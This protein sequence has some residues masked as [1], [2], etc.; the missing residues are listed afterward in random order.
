MPPEETLVGPPREGESWGLAEGDQ[1]VPG[2]LALGPVGGGHDFEVL[3]GWDDHRHSL[4]VVK[5][6][7][8]RLVDDVHV[9]RALA[10]EA[11]LVHDLSHPVIVRGF[12]VA[13]DGPRPHLVLEHLEGPTVSR[14]V[15]RTGPL[16]LHQLL[17][18]AYQLASAL[19]YLANEGVVHLDVKPG[20]VILGA[21]PRLVDL[22]IARSVEEA[23]TVARPLGTDAY[24]APE[25][26][27][28]GGPP[29]GPAADVWGVGAT[30]YE[31][32]SGLAPFPRSERFDPT[33][34]EE[35]F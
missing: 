30:L 12:G 23:A 17:P 20:N 3:L 26:C 25:Q 34:A 22:S 8:P 1:I 29:L 15:R 33:T 27:D 24:M 14:T 9:L 6:V 28:P 31:A 32:A 5:L 19:Q 4:V 2:L 35:R 16:E 11:R 21:P 7:R 18:V 13:L 10:R